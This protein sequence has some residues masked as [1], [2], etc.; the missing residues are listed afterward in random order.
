MKLEDQGLL[1][2]PWFPLLAA[3]S[4][5]ACDSC[6][7]KLDQSS[8]SDSLLLAPLSI[9]SGARVGVVGVRTGVPGTRS[10]LDH[11]DVPGRSRPACSRCSIHGLLGSA[12]IEGSHLF[13]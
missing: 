2:G 3:L 9:N 7:K 10:L 1:D 12:D 13:A 11:P 4:C 8:A 6:S 5:P